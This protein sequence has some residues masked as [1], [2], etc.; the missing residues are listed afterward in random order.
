MKLFVWLEGARLRKLTIGHETDFN[1]P[2]RSWGSGLL[3]IGSGNQFG[4]LGSPLIGSGEILIQ[5]R[6][7]EAEIIIGDHNAFNNGVSVVANQRIRIGNQC[8]IGDLVAIYDSDFHEISPA[9]RNHSAGLT[10]PVCI[11]NN[12]WL[13][14]RVMVL[15]GVSIG[16]NSVVGAMSLVTRSLPANVIAAGVPAKIIRKIE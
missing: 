3:Q 7:V 9:S 15:K 5:P 6:T 8:Q 13:G 2:F 10:A 14:S 11:G 16:D 4:C 12:V 1:V